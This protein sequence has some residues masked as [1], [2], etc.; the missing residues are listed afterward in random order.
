MLLQDFALSSFQGSWFLLWVQSV[1]EKVSFR[2]AKIGDKSVFP[3]PGALGGGKSS[4]C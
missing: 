4:D 2:L 1:T 3:K